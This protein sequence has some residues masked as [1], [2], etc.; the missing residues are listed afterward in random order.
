MI[1]FGTNG[2]KLWIAID[3]NYKKQNSSLIARVSFFVWI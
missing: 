3:N 2:K 1:E